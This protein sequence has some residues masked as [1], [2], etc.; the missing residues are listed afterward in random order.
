MDANT[1]SDFIN[2]QNCIY[3]TIIT[4]LCALLG[5]NIFNSYYRIPKK[6]KEITD[7]SL[8]N[9]RL[10]NRAHINNIKG[11]MAFQD[12]KFS[13]AL[14]FFKLSLNDF[15]SIENYFYLGSIL[16]LIINSLKTNPTILKQE[17]EDLKEILKKLPVKYKT[18]INN[19]L[20]ILENNQIA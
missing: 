17:K 15:I 20:N 8:N 4:V 1:L 9:I 13:A 2:Q 11:I 3:G 16:D 6:I 14:I 12:K 5:L 7:V 10:E 18:Q 19:I